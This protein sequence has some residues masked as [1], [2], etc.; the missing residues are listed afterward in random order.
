[1]Y[2]LGKGLRS[3]PSCVLRRLEEQLAYLR[4]VGHQEAPPT[5]SWSIRR[6]I[7]FDV[8]KPPEVHTP[9][10]T[11]N[12]TGLTSGKSPCRHVG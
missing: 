2:K 12:K 7:E 3:I 9:S 6:F 5:C 8:Y 1:M 4:Q 11:L 10:F